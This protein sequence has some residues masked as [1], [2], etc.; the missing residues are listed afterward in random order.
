MILAN[1]FLFYHRYGIEG[2]VYSSDNSKTKLNSIASISTPLIIYNSHDNS[3]DSIT[4]DGKKISIKLF[5]KVIVQISVDEDLVGGG[6]GG[7]RQKIKLELVKPFV[8]GLSISSTDNSEMIEEDN[9]NNKKDKR[10]NTNGGR[11]KKMKI[12]NM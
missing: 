9:Y 2:I 8:P 6:A 12:E 10:D 5:D 11:K 1:Y 3:L 4:G 7:M